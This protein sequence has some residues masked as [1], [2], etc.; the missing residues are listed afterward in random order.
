MSRHQIFWHT[1]S[2]MVPVCFVRIFLDIH[3]YSMSHSH[4]H[5]RK[6]LTVLTHSYMDRKYVGSVVETTEH[7]D[8]CQLYISVASLLCS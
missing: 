1:V 8:C 4:V 5:K 3:L 6:G 2:S 7:R